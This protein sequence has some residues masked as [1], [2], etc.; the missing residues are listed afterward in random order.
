[1]SFGW[2]EGWLVEILPQ[3]E[4]PAGAI[5]TVD[6]ILRLK[7]I[8]KLK[9]EGKSNNDIS[10]ELGISIATVQRNVKHLKEVS[11][12]DLSPEEISSKRAE[13]DLDLQE[14]QEKAREQFELYSAKNKKDIENAKPTVARAFMISWQSAIEMRAKLFGLDN[15]KQDALVQ[16]NQQNNIQVPDKVSAGT[17][18]KLADA[19]KQEHYKKYD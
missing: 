10:K 9:D 2:G 17:A 14:I 11:V 19:I 16:F 1:M 12:A 15:V 3:N 8:K 6:R 5:K 18:K 7:E 4:M 13:L